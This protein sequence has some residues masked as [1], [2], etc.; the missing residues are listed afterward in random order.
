M[1]KFCFPT[2]KEHIARDETMIKQS[3]EMCKKIFVKTIKKLKCHEKRE[4]VAELAMA[5]GKGGQ[6]FIAK[7]FKVGRDTIRKGIEEIKTGIKY[8]D[9]HNL[10]GRKKITDKLP[11]LE[12]DIK[13]I[14]ESQSQIDPKFQS[15][16]IYTRLTVNEF[17]KQLICK[18]G[19]KY[20]ELPTNQTLNTIINRLGYNLRKIQKTKPKKKIAKTD[21]IFENIAKVQN[22]TRENDKVVWLS[23][24]AKDR[25]KIGKFSRGGKSRVPE[26]AHDHDFGNNYIT[27]FGIMN[28][29][30]K[31]VSI[32]HSKSKI[33]AD[34]I[35]DRIEE[36]WIEN[37]YNK[38]ENELLLNLDNGPECSSRRRQFIKRLVEFS[39]KYNV[40]ITLVYYP[41]YHSKYNP[42]ER[43]WGI[44]EQ[45]W[46][47]DLLDSVETVVNFTKSMTY[48]KK[49]PH[50]ELIEKLYKTGITLTYK[51]MKIY[52]SALSRDECI[53][54]WY[55]IIYPEN[56]RKVVSFLQ[57]E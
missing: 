25:V 42:V 28:V 17:R 16:R 8:I 7:E 30:D 14:A 6:S 33:T 3:I 43:V 12:D 21:D 41:P 48:D 19:Y 54:K 57:K 49:H 52:E 22:A 10:K 24:D 40:K 1:L 37:G 35:V 20:T 34:Y 46:N 13:D 51:E 2:T 47:G 38:T 32:S 29:K 26:E 31:T 56:A 27:P 55:L 5:C 39:A 23:V 11:R 36:Y 18:K 9:N 15:N 44:L 53:G 4:T 50:V 45:H